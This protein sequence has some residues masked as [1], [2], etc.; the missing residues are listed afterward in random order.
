MCKQMIRDAMTA[1]M[2]FMLVWTAA[3][4]GKKGPP[5]PPGFAEPPAVGDLH[6]E[7]DGNTLTLMWTIPEFQKSRKTPIAGSKI[8]RSKQAAADTAC[9][10][11]PLM[12]SVIKK[13][14]R[15][16]AE[17]TYREQLESGYQYAYKVVLY[18]PGGQEGDGSNV[19]RVRY[20]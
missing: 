9:E 6:Y 2:V 1:G 4:C 11:C 7:L 18:A 10:T 3:A 14:P 8:Y 5:V 19:V 13:M 17:M 15:E 16:S 20:E 12:F